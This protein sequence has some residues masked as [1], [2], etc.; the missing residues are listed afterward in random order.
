MNL[1]NRITKDKESG[2]AINRLFSTAMGVFILTSL[3]SAIGPTIDGIVVGSYYKLDEVAA[4]GLTSFLL[5][6]IRTLAASIISTG[7]NVIVSRL[8][9]SGDKE[10][11]NRAFSLSL[12][13]ALAL[14]GLMAAV[15]IIFSNQIAIMLGARGALAHLM[16]PTS[17][18]LIG[19][20]LGLPFYAVYII[21]LSYLK[22]DG[23]YS[24]VTLSTV[25]MTIVDI[26]ADLYVVKC[27]DGGLFMIGLAT[28]AGHVIAFL[29]ALSHFFL[30]KTIFHFSLKGLQLQQGIEM[31]R[32]GLTTG[33]TKLSTTACG[34]LINNM[35]VFFAGSEVIA[36]F[37]VGNQVLKFCFCFWMGAASTLMSFTS[38]LMGEEDREALGSVQK[39]A[40]KHSLRITCLA[41]ALIFVFSGPI[42]VLFV[43]NGDPSVISIAGESIRFFRPIDA[44]Q[45][46]RLLLS[47]LPDR[48]E[49]AFSREYIQFHA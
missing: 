15:C 21:F 7:S 41:A 44:V 25:A 31:L 46:D 1:L 34:V 12:I 32:T 33:I 26:L 14:S 43:K 9:G 48:G 17:D 18:Y 28:T 5:V 4:I 2:T 13:L 42:A 8:I 6:G 29:I 47:V 36:A 23:D 30:K 37:G 39:T 24:F 45:R 19:Y 49:T 40:L 38:M 20:C 22:M 11:A 35:L 27:T 3:V 16:K 10:S